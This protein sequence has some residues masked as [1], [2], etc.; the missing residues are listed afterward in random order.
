MIPATKGEEVG[1][2]W[3]C[4]DEVDDH[5]CTSMGSV[6]TAQV[7][8]RPF[9]LGTMR[10]AEGPSEANAD[11]SATL[12]VCALSRA[13]EEYEVIPLTVARRPAGKRTRRKPRVEATTLP[14]EA[15]RSRVARTVSD[16]IESTDDSMRRIT[17]PLVAREEQPMPMESCWCWMIS[18]KA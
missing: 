14:I 5:E 9:V 13:S 17:S 4:A 10:R 15:R 1:G 6:A 18:V 8:K 3:A 11:A 7:Q 2:S 12:A 16:G